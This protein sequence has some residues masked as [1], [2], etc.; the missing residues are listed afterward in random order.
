MGFS[1]LSNFRSSSISEIVLEAFLAWMNH[2]EREFCMKS[3]AIMVYYQLR[4][5]CPIRGVVLFIWMKLQRMEQYDIQR[6]EAIIR[7][8]SMHGCGIYHH[9]SWYLISLNAC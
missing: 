1:N 6:N 9:V 5:I 2:F 7:F 8:G 4:T 3:V